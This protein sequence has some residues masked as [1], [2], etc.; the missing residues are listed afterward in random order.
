MKLSYSA[1]AY[2]DQSTFE[3]NLVFFLNFKMD[4]ANYPSILTFR[5]VLIFYIY[6]KRFMHKNNQGIIDYSIENWG[7]AQ[8]PPVEE[9][10]NKI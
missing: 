3:N 7:T 8:C 6:P 1:I 2:K 4:I 9:S 5:Y 10:I